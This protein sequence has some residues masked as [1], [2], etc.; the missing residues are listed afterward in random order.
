MTHKYTF[1]FQFIFSFF[2]Y[3]MPSASR[4]SILKHFRRKKARCL[5]FRWNLQLW[6][7]CI[8][9]FRWAA[10]LLNEDTFSSD[11][12]NFRF[13]H[14]AIWLEKPN[15]ICGS[16]D[17]FGK[18]APIITYD[19]ISMNMSAYYFFS[20]TVLQLDVMWHHPRTNHWHHINQ[21]Q[22]PVWWFYKIVEAQPSCPV[23]RLNHLKK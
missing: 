5:R 17:S 4:L 9:S 15:F 18:N 21:D 16:R 20:K 8:T 19:C 23:H 13:W 11:F 22:I 7:Q 1:N 14:T 12:K 2:M 6:H 10:M 3:L